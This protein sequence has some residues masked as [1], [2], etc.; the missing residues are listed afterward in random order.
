[1]TYV[2]ENEVLHDGFNHPVTPE[3]LVLPV[4]GVNSLHNPGLWF[5]FLSGPA[6]LYDEK[7]LGRWSDLSPLPTS[8][9]TGFKVGSITLLP[10]P[11]LQRSSSGPAT[12]RAYERAT[13]VLLPGRETEDSVTFRI[14]PSIKLPTVAAWIGE[15]GSVRLYFECGTAPTPMSSYLKV[16][17]GGEVVDLTQT[18]CETGW[19]LTAVNMVPSLP[20]VLEIRVGALAGTNRIF[21]LVVG[22]EYGATP[23]EMDFVRRALREA[24]WRFYGVTGGSHL[25]STFTYLEPPNCGGA[26]ICWRNTTE[27]LQGDAVTHPSGSTPSI[28]VDIC[29]D[30][31]GLSGAD[32]PGDNERI[33]AHEFGHLLTG[34]G[35]LNYLGDEYWESNS[36]AQICGE[37]GVYIHRCSH[38]IMARN[39]E[40][41]ASLCTSFTHDAATQVQRQ[42]AA[43]SYTTIGMRSDNWG[44]AVTTVTECLDGTTNYAGTHGS[45]AWDV[46][47]NSGA[48]PFAHPK[49]SPDNHTFRNFANA[50]SSVVG[51]NL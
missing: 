5:R 10:D 36:L 31:T 39:P 19:Y 42:N 23:D 24:A 37:S 8:E 22:L 14:D 7:A 29:R 12:L 30:L 35:V 46:L 25:I 43:G 15:T 49:W 4:D 11:D 44:T 41:M 34:N 50:A 9:S 17:L 45:P 1:M 21:D 28:T 27:C 48:A 6:A 18:E 40:T 20:H 33:M 26:H 38:S 47:A 2:P 51:N 3:T 16:E 32:D 13:I